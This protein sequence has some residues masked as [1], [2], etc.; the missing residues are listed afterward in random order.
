MSNEYF[1]PSYVSRRTLAR[2]EAMNANLLALE[3]AFDRLPPRETFARSLTSFVEATAIGNAYAV[4]LTPAPTRYLSGLTVLVKVPSANTGPATINVDNLGARS[5]RRADG[6][7]LAA[8]DLVA[9][10][11]ILSTYDG[12]N[13]VL[14]SA[15]ASST[16][17]A[18]LLDIPRIAVR[19]N[20]NL[21]DPG[22]T[23]VGDLDTGM[24]SPS[25]NLINFKAGGSIQFTIASSGVSGPA[26]GLTGL[27]AS[28]VSIGTLSAS[29]L[30]LEAHVNND[31]LRAAAGTVAL[32]GMTFDSDTNT[33]IFWA[34]ADVLGFAGGGTE[35]GRWSASGLLVGTTQLLPIGSGATGAVLSSAGQGRFSTTGAA[36]L[37]VNRVEAG[38]LQAFQFNG[39][40]VGSISITSTATA[41]NTSSDY[42]LKT[43]AE[44]PDGFDPADLI[45][46]LAYAQ[47]WYTWNDAPEKLDLG[48]FAHELAEILPA[49]VTGERDAVDDDGNPIYQGRDDSKLIPVLVAALDKA[50]SRIATLEADMADLKGICHG[51]T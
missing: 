13:F 40:T 35:M 26:G 42:R 20:N 30:P 28:N 3:V 17:G 18:N 37:F 14:L 22:Y 4:A 41:Y 21:E 9:G 31:V 49:A 10:G 43:G 51:N 24:F 19:K 6:T 5:I 38:A 11:T 2:A 29:R 8:G 39:A 46:R 25:S 33:G 50:L 34:S 48:W 15:S 44:S 7:D 36:A 47:R 16:T 23:F 32:P 27:N 1:A 45:E 12:T